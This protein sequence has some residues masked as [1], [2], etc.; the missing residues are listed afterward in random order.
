MS[1]LDLEQ[2]D[3]DVTYWQVVEDRPNEYGGKLLGAPLSAKLSNREASREA[4]AAIKST[5]LQA[6]VSRVT[7]FFNEDCPNDV[8]F[9]KSL[10]EELRS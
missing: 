1:N 3:F 10:L 8:A 4:L 9:R 5:N 7:L 6:Y 2:G